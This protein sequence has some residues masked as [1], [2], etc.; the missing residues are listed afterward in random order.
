MNVR[1]PDPRDLRIAQVMSARRLWTSAG[2][3][4][5]LTRR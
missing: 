1:N 2:Y 4:A 3:G 5:L